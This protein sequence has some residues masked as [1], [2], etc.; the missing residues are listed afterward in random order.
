MTDEGTP[1][2]DELLQV[3]G[4]M[5]GLVGAGHVASFPKL[6]DGF[7]PETG[8]RYPIKA[9]VFLVCSGHV[10]S[11]V[12]FGW[13]FSDEHSEERIAM[14]STF[15]GGVNEQLELRIEKWKEM[16]VSVVSI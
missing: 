1:V 8:R 2:E 10:S 11:D 14:F 5:V 7:S 15:K 4:D 12:I 13:M 3:P 9:F 16:L 6:E